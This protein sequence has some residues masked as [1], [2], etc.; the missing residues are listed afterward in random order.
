VAEAELTGALGQSRPC[1]VLVAQVGDYVA[2]E[3]SFQ[4]M[5]RTVAAGDVASIRAMAE[6]SQEEADQRAGFA[7]RRD[8]NLQPAELILNNW[9]LLADNE[10]RC[11]TRDSATANFY[12]RWLSPAI[13]DE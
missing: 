12:R 5:P 7:P 3:A 6:G 4:T 11:A 2:M 1:G 13:F 9:P 8:S 10:N